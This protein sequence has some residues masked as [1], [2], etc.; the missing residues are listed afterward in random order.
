MRLL[1]AFSL[2]AVLLA[3]IGLYG[4]VSYTVTQR[5]RELGL[6]VALGATPLDILRLV[7]ARGLATVGAGLAVGVVAAFVLT[8]FLE[9]LLFNV[10]ATDP[11]TMAAAVVSLA[12]VALVVHWLPARRAV[13]VDPVVAL[14][15]E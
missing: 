10:R 4:V 1:G 5:T 15:Q 7:F 12:V 11:W 2:L 6:R 3:A 14:R 9:S 13:R 8:N